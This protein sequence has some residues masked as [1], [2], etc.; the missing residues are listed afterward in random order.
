MQKKKILKKT[1]I[2]KTRLYAKLAIGIVGTPGYP[3]PVPRARTAGAGVQFQ[4]PP[5]L[6]TSAAL[7]SKRTRPPKGFPDIS[8]IAVASR[9]LYCALLSLAWHAPGSAFAYISR[10]L[11]R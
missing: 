8:A 4:F 7:L 1:E 2:K 6:A 5:T 9:H 11:R 10:R 3:V